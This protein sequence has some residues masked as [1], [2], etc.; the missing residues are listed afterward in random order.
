MY[1][2]GL[3]YE[4]LCMYQSISTAILMRRFVSH[5]IMYQ[6]T[7]VKFRGPRPL[8]PKEINGLLVPPG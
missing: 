7:V 2:N 8:G 6:P 5:W 4:L 1:E 3:Y